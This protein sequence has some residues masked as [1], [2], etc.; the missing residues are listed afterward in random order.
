[1]AIKISEFG[2]F[3]IEHKKGTLL[4]D[5]DGL[6]RL[7]AREPISSDEENINISTLFV[8][9]LTTPFLLSAPL[10]D[11]FVISTKNRMEDQ[12]SKTKQFSINSELLFYSPLGTT[13]TFRPVPVLTA[14]LTKHVLEEFHSSLLGGLQGTEMT[15]H[16]IRNNFYCPKMRSKVRSS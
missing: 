5:A 8:G 13:A 16:R 12:P 14:A 4:K 7:P 9:F 6:S 3:K 11:P 1:M 2:D 15:F 10:T